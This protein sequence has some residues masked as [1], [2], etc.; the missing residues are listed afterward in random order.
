MV[1]SHPRERQHRVDG[2]G[3]T[4]LRHASLRRQK[5]VAGMEQI[6]VAMIPAVLAGIV[7]QLEA[8]DG[9]LTLKTEPVL[10]GTIGPQEDWIDI[11]ELRRMIPG[12]PKIELVR[13][14]LYFHG[15]PH[16]KSGRTTLFRRQEIEAWIERSQK[17][18]LGDFWTK[19]RKYKNNE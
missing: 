7:K 13:S 4:V 3:A 8:I 10:N 2:G 11:Y 18:G 5:E 1:T 6:N 17:Y 19:K 9:W 14:W 12:N 15:I 16:Y